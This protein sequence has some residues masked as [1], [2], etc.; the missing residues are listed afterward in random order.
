MQINSLN[1]FDR[2]VAAC[3]GGFCLSDAGVELSS[4]AS[5]GF[6]LD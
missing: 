4:R 1:V 5:T 2:L 3:E 6:A